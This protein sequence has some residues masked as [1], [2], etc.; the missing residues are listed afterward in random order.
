LKGHGSGQDTLRPSF[1]HKGDLP[2]REKWT[3]NKRQRLRE[4]EEGILAWEQEK[5]T[6]G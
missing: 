5:T 4:K 6:S 3:G 2:Q 1:Q